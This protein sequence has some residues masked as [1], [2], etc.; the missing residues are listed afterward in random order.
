MKTKLLACLLLALT[1]PALALAQGK[2]ILPQGHDD[3]RKL[4]QQDNSGPCEKCGVVTDV[5]GEARPPGSRTPAH[6]TDGGIGGNLVTTPIIGSGSVVS[7]A[8]NA[9]K[10]TT[11][12]KMTVRFDDGTYGFFEDDDEPDVH[13][14]DRVKIVDGQIVHISD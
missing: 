13:K 2:L 3:M 10:S 8:R 1:L 5:H 12:Y 14:G 9:H 11:Y 6:P 7:D 4:M